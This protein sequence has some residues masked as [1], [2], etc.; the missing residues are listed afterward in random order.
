MY[1]SYNSTAEKKYNPKYQIDMAKILEF[2]TGIQKSMGGKTQGNTIVLTSYGQNPETGENL[3][4]KI[5][6]YSTDDKQFPEAIAQTIE[7]NQ[8][9]HRNF[10]IG[11]HIMRHGLPASSRGGLKDIMAVL[12]FVSDFDDDRAPEYMNRLP[13]GMTPS[14]VLETS[15]N[16]FQCGFLLKEPLHDL[17]QARE[18]ATRLKAYCKC[19][20][21]TADIAHVWRIP[22]ALNWPNQKKV[23]EG[24]SPEPQLV[25][26]L[27]LNDIRYSPEDLLKY[28]PSVE[29]QIS[30]SLP[31]D[32]N[33]INSSHTPINTGNDMDLLQASFKWQNGSKIERLFNGSLSD[34]GEDH[35]AADQALCNYLSFLYQGDYGR[36][37]A[38]FRQ[39]GL[40]RDKWDEKHASNGASYGMMTINNAIAGTTSF[41][42]PTG[43]THLY[44]SPPPV[45]ECQSKVEPI[46]QEWEKPVPLKEEQALKLDPNL[47][48]GIIGDMARAVSIE[49]ESPFELSAGLILSVIAT[50][51]QG[52]FMIQVKPGYQEPG[53]I[54]TVTALDPANRKSSVLMKITRPLTQW[55]KQKHLE[56]EPWIK[57]AIS[58]LKNQEARLKSLRTQYGKAKQEDLADIE[59]EITEI[60]NNPIQVPMYPKIWAQDVT[61]EHLGTLLNNHD[62]KMSILSAEGGIFDIIGGRYSNGVANLDL[63][64]QG[65]S[66]DPV[67]VD[68]GSRD[69]VYLNHPALTLGLSPQPEVLRGLTD[70]PGFRGKGLLA[71]FL[72]LLPESNLGYRGL[73]S[74][75]VPEHISGSYHNLIFQLLDIEPGEDESGEKQ[76]YILK[77]SQVAYQE[78]ADFFMVVERDLREGGRFEHITDWA[79]KLPG[80]AVRIAALL[81]CAKIPNQ[82]WAQE[83]E[84]DTMTTTLD[85]A[86][87]FAS[88]A[89]IAFDLM[90]TDKSLEQAR[91]VWRWIERNRHQEFSKR[92]CFNALKGSF[93]R[94]TNMEEPLKILIERNHIR[95]VSK[96]KRVGKP[97][98]KY[99]VNPEILKGWS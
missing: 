39:S 9:Q 88:H 20:H 82:P 33:R 35:S 81:H 15:E 83:I 79:G 7:Q 12:G 92:D 1:D 23:R 97:S 4:P 32:L 60:E 91:K 26:L 71:R 48:T 45:E 31:V 99:A 49:T 54:W 16:R 30:P 44:E 75:S 6:Q 37:D 59:A 58:K 98:V 85:I 69:P 65:H 2:F 72:Y 67:R 19:D 64:L 96:E 36:I 66:G 22:G 61:P 41:Y 87:V 93:H 53:N 14:Y 86:S 8:E 38:M 55:E 63:F 43:G 73:D 5:W 62:E 27:F 42:N 78:W 56:L 89:L 40:M 90:G 18:I 34:Y 84:L 74:E 24:R 77:L 25:K 11:L 29:E 10:Y 57:D 52:K 47:L 80:A 46:L 50:A 76:P 21:G 13:Q 28:L 3:K 17:E 70:K 95:E 68:R 51:C 94:V